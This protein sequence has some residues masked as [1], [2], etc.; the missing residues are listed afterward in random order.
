MHALKIII[1][2][3]ALEFYMKPLQSS[4]SSCILLPVYSPLCS[5]KFEATIYLA[6]SLGTVSV[7]LSYP[8]S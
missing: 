7:E 2:S 4:S 1:V 6:D 5:E 3:S 8:F